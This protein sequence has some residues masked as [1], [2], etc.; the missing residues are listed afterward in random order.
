MSQAK[1]TL[2]A[3]ATAV[4]NAVQQGTLIQDKVL[5]R[6]PTNGQKFT[7][8]VFDRADGF[9]V[10]DT[11]V[12]RK[13]KPAELEFGSSE[14]TASCVDQAL[15]APVPNADVKNWEDAVRN[16]AKALPDPRLRASRQV[17]Q[18]L[19]NRREK[20]VADLVMNP[21]NYGAD[22]KLVL[23]GTSMWSDYDNSKP[24]RAIKDA[25]DNMLMRANNFAMGRKV[26]SWLS[27][28]PGICAAVY[29]NGAAAGQVTLQ[30][31]AELFELP[32]L[33]LV[34]DGFLN[35][36]PK[37][38]PVSMQRIWGNDALAFYQDMNADPD[39]G[40]TFGFT[41]E[42]EGRQAGTIED[43]D[44]GARGG[45]RLRVY[46]SVKELL[47]APDLAF[48]WKNCVTG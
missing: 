9:T 5:P 14:L 34:G 40:I 4:A 23:S 6:V 17:T 28:H 32:N 11:E 47:I 20:R 2:H 26:W 46:E 18:A 41:G 12:G 39:F 25:L 13:G 21:A 31:F 30:Q 16:G 45:Q 7:Y 44:M 1:F 22:N 19:L 8:S 38:Q 15:D 29:K 36:A 24:Q 33:P 48:L 35:V 37:G 43:S 10:P 3:G 42:W 27:T